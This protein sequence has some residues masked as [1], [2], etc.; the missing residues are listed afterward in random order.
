VILSLVVWISFYIA[1]PDTPLN[2]SETTAV[3]GACAVVVLCCK[4]IGA[5]FRKSHPSQ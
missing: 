5:R 3:V 2:L 4:W 1:T